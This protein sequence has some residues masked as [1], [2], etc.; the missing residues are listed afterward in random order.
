M[1]FACRIIWLRMMV[2]I[3]AVF[4]FSLQTGLAEEEASPE[5]SDALKAKALNRISSILTHKAYAYD[6]DFSQWDEIVDEHREAIDG[7]RTEEAFAK[8]V[9]ECFDRFGISHLAIQ[10]PLSRKQSKTG[11]VRKLVG[12]FMTQENE[13]FFVSRIVKSSPAY[14]AGIRRG[15][16]IV[17]IDGVLIKDRPQSDPDA[18]SK[19]VQWI[20]DDQVFKKEIEIRDH[21]TDDPVSLQWLE[22]NV[23]LVTVMS[24]DGKYYKFGAVNRVMR[25]AKKARAIILDMRG[26]YGGYVHNYLHLAGHFACP[27]EAFHLRVNRKQAGKIR[28]ESADTILSRE[29][30]LTAGTRG[31]PWGLPKK[32]F[33][34]PTVV[35]VD[36]HCASGGELFPAAM[37]D[38]GKAIVIGSQTKGALLVSRSA[39]LA[40][41]FH[42]SY[43]VYEIA[44]PGGKRIEGL[45]LEPDV[46]L[47]GK[48]VATDE[49]V[50]AKAIEAIENWAL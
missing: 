44:P 23:A 49:L 39:R 10:T 26:N 7:A 12:I 31:R 48:E 37:R 33:N 46:V 5:I 6:T 41:G 32:K 43:P 45:G 38:L 19:R 30:L 29:D 47:S 42:M 16:T 35:L 50:F 13:E 40:N 25:E 15:D 14:E 1:N 18:T 24:F 21:P 8:A 34:G 27:G 36:R 22:E 20:R 9:Q 3:L 28:Q 17:S 4:V 2:T 11:K